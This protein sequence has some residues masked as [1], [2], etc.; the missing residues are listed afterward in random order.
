MISSHYKGTK[1]AD[2]EGIKTE[3][4]YEKMSGEETIPLKSEIISN[5]SK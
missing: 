1:R 5:G 4:T 3:A 2:A